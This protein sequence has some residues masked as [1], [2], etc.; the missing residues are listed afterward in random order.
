MDAHPAIDHSQATLK[1]IAA[2]L[3]ALADLAELAGGRSTVVRALV[4]LILRPAEA[5]ARRLVMDVYGDMD[6]TPLP[7]LQDDDGSTAAIR[8]A[9]SFRALAIALAY[10]PE[11][12]F[13]DGDLQAI[14]LWLRPVAACLGNLREVCEALR[15]MLA[16]AR[17]DSS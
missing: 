6:V 12:A 13:E 8:L 3:F 2:L 4:L 11:W 10:L 9:L 16:P 7:H 15:H 14:D 17:L 1:R 5:A